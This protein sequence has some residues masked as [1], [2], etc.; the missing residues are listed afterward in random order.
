MAFH[1][2]LPKS[3]QGAKRGTNHSVTVPSASDSHCCLCLL[4]CS[5]V[6]ASSVYIH[7]V[8]FRD[9]VDVSRPRCFCREMLRSNREMFHGRPGYKGDVWELLCFHQEDIHPGSIWGCSG[10]HFRSTE[11]VLV[12]WADVWEPPLVP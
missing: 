2:V 5:A 6:H 8:L 4:H 3:K 12:P 11:S 7:M 9:M 10:T 1:K